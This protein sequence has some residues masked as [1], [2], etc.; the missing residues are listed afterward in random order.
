[1]YY[2][3]INYNLRWPYWWSNVNS[4]ISWWVNGCVADYILLILSIIYNFWWPNWWNDFNVIICWW[5]NC[6]NSLFILK[7]DNSISLIINLN[8]LHIVC[9]LGL[10]ISI[11]KRN[12]RTEGCI[13][14]NIVNLL[15]TVILN[16]HHIFIVFDI[17]TWINDLSLRWVW[18]RQDFSNRWVL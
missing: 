12:Q 15:I 7:R 2:W 8:N 13:S 3:S 16:N 17:Y 14:L 11:N 5:L 4:V 1:L 10:S 18:S 9:I 6:W